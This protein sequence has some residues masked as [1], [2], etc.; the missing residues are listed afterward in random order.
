MT[1]NTEEYTAAV[2]RAAA[3]GLEVKPVWD[4]STERTIWQVFNPASGSIHYVRITPV[5]HLSCDCASRVYCC[6]RAAVREH[7]V[8]ERS[9]RD[10]QV[11]A[12]RK[13]ADRRDRAFLASHA[14]VAFS[15]FK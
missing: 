5:G 2:K 6:C 1:T 8:A 12:A 13:A 15:I 11:A 3:K 7:L 10:L 14:P 4:T 9:A